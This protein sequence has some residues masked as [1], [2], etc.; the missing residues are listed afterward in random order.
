MTRLPGE[1]EG[2]LAEFRKGRRVALARA[3]SL[4]ENER[5]GFRSFLQ[6]LLDEPAEP[7][8]R[9]G[10]T[11]PPGSG[12]ST[13]AA[14]LARLIQNRN[15]SVGILAVDPTSPYSGGA[16]LGD[17]IRMNEVPNDQDFFFRSMASRG[18]LGGLSTASRAVLDVM[19]RFGF[20]WLIIE[21]VGAGQVE[22]EIADVADTVVVVLIPESGDG[23]QVMKAG[24]FEVAD[25]FVVNKS[26]LEGADRL[27]G[28][29]RSMLEFR[30]SGIP[31]ADSSSNE[32]A[33]MS[34]VVPTEARTGE[35]IARLAEEI[36]RHRAHLEESGTLQMR[37][38][39]RILARVRDLLDREL[40]RR[41]RDLLSTEELSDA[42]VDRIL[43]GSVTPYAAAYELLRRMGI[44]RDELDIE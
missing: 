34:P 5:P 35:G 32:E 7:A 19:D 17:R 25:L 4:V 12:K 8:I 30:A 39:K 16:L 42:V 23:V 3:I 1:L 41:A 44:D 22:T 13:V 20:D 18:S 40:M 6:A 38:R 37:R 10:L 31:E 43:S 15:E 2:L 24:M 33:W 29:L 11:G 28:D 36:G 26:D 9:V 27:T 14:K 21:T